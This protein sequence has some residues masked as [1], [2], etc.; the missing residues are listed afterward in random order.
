MDAESGLTGL[1]RVAIAVFVLLGT[2]IFYGY[3]FASANLR[4]QLPA[5]ASLLDPTLYPRDFYVREMMQFNPRFYYY[6]LMEFPA[7]LGFDISTI[8]FIYYLIALASFVSGL[9]A[10]ARFLCRDFISAATLP[11]L[12]LSAANGTIGFTDLFRTEPIPAT[13]AIAV[14]IWGVYHCFK[15]R[16]IIGYG[17]FGCACL[18]QFLVGIIPG[19]LFAPIAILEAYIGFKF[20]S[21]KRDFKEGFEEI[22]SSSKFLIIAFLLLTLFAACVYLPMKLTGGTGSDLMDDQQ[23]IYLYGYI[24][25][26][27]HVIYSKFGLT[28]SRGWINWIGF[29]V[30]GWIL[31]SISSVFKSEDKFKLRV[32]FIA[33]LGLLLLGYVF[34]EIIPIAT[35][36]KLQLARTTPF[37]QLVV[38]M[39]IAAWVSQS[40]RSGNLPL[41]CL[42][43]AL[44][45]IKNSGILLAITAIKLWF[46]QR[47]LS[48]LK[49]RQVYFYIVGLML[50]L[51]ILLCSYFGLI[52]T[53]LFLGSIK[54]IQTPSQ[55]LGWID[56][57]S[58]FLLL[59]T[60][61]L[62]YHY[63]LFLFLTLFLPAI[64]PLPRFPKLLK[65]ALLSILIIVAFSW[66]P[67]RLKIVA[68]PDEPVEILGERFRQQSPQD[69]LVLVPPSDE[70]FRFYSQRSVVWSF[71][72]FPFTDR[73]ILKWEDRMQQITGTVDAS[74]A[75][76]DD[77]YRQK[78]G[79]E[80]V[81]I[82]QSFQ[83]DYILTRTD[84]HPEL[85][86]TLLD[87]VENWGIW[88]VDPPQPPLIRGE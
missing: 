82:A 30:A 80:L 13:F 48:R 18:L 27:H 65:V 36:A 6:H 70:D 29:A 34:V 32:I 3:E 87:T 53:L 49:N 4:N 41:G 31:I 61:V 78:S 60:F 64:A 28:G 43:I 33:A 9:Y 44:I 62:N 51:S 50:I 74:R 14:S 57:G 19:I 88:Q 16:W 73:G 77:R 79:S 23:F 39:A 55:K 69:A 1:R 47:H 2:T 15:S 59:L 45:V 26:P 84:W 21:K 63:D 85:P 66:M 71:K 81:A 72:S 56:Y 58:L 7:R 67:N 17:L 8:T 54:R 5:I 83:A 35:F 12:G 46:A 11:F 22:L 75:D 42:L 38:L 25:H 40:Y 10:I 76:L 86:G 52:F 37:I 68:K 24:R 20:D